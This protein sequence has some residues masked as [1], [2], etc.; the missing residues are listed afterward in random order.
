MDPSIEEFSTA[1]KI[2][3]LQ[4][5][6]QAEKNVALRATRLGFE[7]KLASIDLTDPVAA[8]A[9]ARPLL[10]EWNVVSQDLRWFDDCLNDKGLS[11]AKQSGQEVLE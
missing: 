1:G 5:H 9:L 4:R 8:E 3:I 10:D 2:I 11:E 6:G 7:A